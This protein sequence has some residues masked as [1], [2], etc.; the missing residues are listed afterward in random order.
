MDADL[1]C[2]CDDRINARMPGT[3]SNFTARREA[4][5][6]KVFRVQA[7]A[8]EGFDRQIR[9]DVGA[10]G[11]A[12][13]TTFPVQAIR[14]FIRRLPVEYRA[15]YHRHRRRTNFSLSAGGLSGR[16]LWGPRKGAAG[17]LLPHHRNY[18]GS[19]GNRVLYR[20]RLYA[21]VHQERAIRRRK[22]VAIRLQPVLSGTCARL[23]AC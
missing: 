10:G 23:T 8:R 7:E 21:A 12:V 4:R 1:C 19:A 5:V 14:S 22:L 3:L 9:R 17:P 13:A 15:I 2:G 20:A 6:G 11:V 18:S 16:A